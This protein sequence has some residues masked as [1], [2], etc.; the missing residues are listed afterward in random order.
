M[1]K[2]KHHPLLSVIIAVVLNNLA[3]I[4]SIIIGILAFWLTQ[5]EIICFMELPRAVIVVFTILLCVFLIHYKVRHSIISKHLAIV[6]IC[7]AMLYFIWC[8]IFCYIIQ[9]I[10]VSIIKLY[11]N[12]IAI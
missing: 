4:V 2:Q 10:F 8:F 6:L 9:P 12:S 5:E 7:L 3:I 11:L 1:E